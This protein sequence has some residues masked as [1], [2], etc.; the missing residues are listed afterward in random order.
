MSTTPTTQQGQLAL[1]LA[2]LKLCSRDLTAAHNDAV[3]A[4][5]TGFLSSARHSRAV[6]LADKL[7]DA[8]AFAERLAFVVEGDLRAEDDGLSS[9]RLIQSNSMVEVAIELA[10]FG[11]TF[12]LMG[13]DPEH[14]VKLA[15]AIGAQ[16]KQ[17]PDDEDEDDAQ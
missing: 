12:A 7:A 11:A 2:H 6:E 17:E 15:D 8:I 3:A 16:V 13:R 14:A 9:G 4:A 10:G 1:A 5:A